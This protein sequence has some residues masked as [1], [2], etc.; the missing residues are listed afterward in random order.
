MCLLF[1]L[2]LLRILLKRRSIFDVDVLFEYFIRD[3]RLACFDE[4]SY[5]LVPL[6]FPP[7]SMQYR[8]E[9]LKHIKVLNK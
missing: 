3:S 6:L 7:D 8:I 2:A 5:V 4:V 1:S 9:W